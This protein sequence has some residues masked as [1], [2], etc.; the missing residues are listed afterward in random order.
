[1]LKKWLALLMTVCLIT[2]AAAGTAYGQSQAGNSGIV[3]LLPDG[4]PLL[5]DGSMWVDYSAQPL[6]RIS[7]PVNGN[8]TSIAGSGLS[9][10]G[11]TKD[12]KLVRWNGSGLQP[13]TWTGSAK[14]VGDGHWLAADGTVWS[15]KDSTPQAVDGFKGISVFD[16]FQSILGGVASSGSVMYQNP[17]FHAAPVILGQIPDAPA[18]VKMEV[19]ADLAAVLYNDG[20]LVLFSTLLINGSKTYVSQTIATDGADI[21]LGK[22]D[23]LLYLKKDGT[24]WSA[25]L[26]LSTQKFDS[27]RVSG[28]ENAEKVVAISGA[29]GFFARQQDGSWVEYDNGQLHKVEIPRIDRISFKVSNSKPKV[30]DSITPTVEIQYGSGEKAKLPPGLIQISIDK[31][32]L[33]KPLDSGKIKVLGVGEANV[34]VEV[35]GLKQT[36]GIVSG[37]GKPI[38]KGKQEKGVTY[39]PLKPVFQALGGTVDYQASSKTFTIKVGDTE[40][41]VTTG[42]KKAKVNGKA[43]TMK[44]API[45]NK[46]ETLV[47]ADLLSS[48]LGAKLK[49]NASKQ[50]MTVTLGAAQMTVKAD[51]NKPQTSKPSSGAGKM[52]DVPATGDMAGWRILKGHEYQKSLRIYYQYENGILSVT[53]EDIRKV[54]L[55]RKIT[56]IDDYGNKRTNT[57]REIYYLFGLSNEYT[58]EWLYKKFGDLYADWLLSSTVNADR[59]VEDYLQK[60]GRMQTYGSVTLT[61]DAEFEYE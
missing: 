8:L 61:P 30:G 25:R 51:Q 57:V 12:G 24:A 48:A 43:V 11:I 31:P 17:K 47:P 15:M 1:M 16:E 7:I 60:T 34:S 56:W 38:G 3:A 39:L 10:Y 5:E 36:V 18:V 19:S 4:T 23:K 58:S 13:V 46:G 22:E 41:A 44:G 52:Y 50:E 14:Q 20:R 28:I 59:I 42:S 9:G 6:N 55:N 27:V 54:N 33:L 37:L 21:S 29:K 53:V 49:W 2:P 26:D 40:I 45:L 32:Y 35:G